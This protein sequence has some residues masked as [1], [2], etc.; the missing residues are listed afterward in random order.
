MDEIAELKAECEEIQRNAWQAYKRGDISRE[1]ALAIIG[2]AEKDLFLGQYETVE[3]VR[4]E[5]Q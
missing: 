1:D 3:S 2:R 5:T 4:K